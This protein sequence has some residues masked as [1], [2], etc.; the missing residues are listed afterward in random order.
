MRIVFTS[1][2]YSS[3]FSDPASWL[4]RIEGYVGI[5]EAL[6]Q[7]HE[8][9]SIEQINYEGTYKQNGV[10]YRF[11]K[12]NNKWFPTGLNNY[13]K[14]LKPDV[15]FVHGMH[16]PLQ[17]IQLIRKLPKNVKL[18][19]QN[20]AEKPATGLKK[21]L[22]SFADRRIDGYF[23]TSLE[24]GEPWIEAKII[25]SPKK[26]HEVM[27]ASSVFHP[28]SKVEARRQTH[29]KGDSVF[30]WV[31]RLDANK[32]PV[33]VVKA[34]VQFLSYQPRASLYMI[35]HTEELI[36]EIKNII[37]PH[38]ENISLVGSML[39][40]QLQVWFNSADFIISGSHYEGGGI[41]VCEGM[42][43]GCIPL[44]TNIASFRMMTAGGSCGKLYVPGNVETLLSV[45]RQTVE[46]D[47]EKEKEKVLNQFQ[48]AL[49][50][51]AIAERITQVLVSS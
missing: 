27:E 30:L 43:C 25:R 24:L 2:V 22:Q 26:I 1:Y 4:R 8:V 28:M 38:K 10:D 9:I 34:F 17:V 45:L 47:L 48:S 7:H 39:H 18:F 40:E 19:A 44:L 3:N 16:F 29:V 14:N 42:S 11:L 46:M 49:S 13:I 33:N 37:E 12:E 21:F 50:F 23:F 36:E 35:F 31:G 15:V 6:S 5:L 20:H 32:D 51:Q 41:A